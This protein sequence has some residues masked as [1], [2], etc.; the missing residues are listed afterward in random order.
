MDAQ[1]D[2]ELLERG[3]ERAISNALSRMV[4]G[5]H[6]GEHSGQRETRPHGDTT[7]D[8]HVA[9]GTEGLTLLRSD[10]VGRNQPKRRYTSFTLLA[11]SMV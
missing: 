11:K 8:S 10:N 7:D 4:R 3:L 9:G 1:L 5:D 6:R 2:A